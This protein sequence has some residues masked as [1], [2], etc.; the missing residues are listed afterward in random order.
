MPKYINIL[1]PEVYNKIAAGEVVERPASA[2]KEI[3]ENSID[4]GATKIDIEIEQGGLGLIAVTDNGCGIYEEDL[5]AVFMKH[6]T[7]KLASVTD[8][9]SVQ[10]L[11]FRGEALSSIAAVSSVTL[12]TRTSKAEYGTKISVEDGKIISKEYVSCNVGTRI[13]VRDLFYNVPAR[14]KFLKPPAKETAELTRCAQRLILTNFS[15]A[16]SYTLDG[17]TVYE[18]KGQSAEESVYAV[19]GSVCL[20]N[21]LPINFDNGAFFRLNGYIS[22]PEFIKSNTTYQTISVNGRCIEDKT[23]QNSVMQAYK[24]YY[25]GNGRHFPLYVLNIDI[26]S[27]QVDVN[28]HP[29]KTEIRF[30]NIS[31]VAGTCY[32]VVKDALKEFVTFRSMSIMG[33]PDI[34]G[35]YDKVQPLTD[36][37]SESF[38]TS[39]SLF[40]NVSNDMQYAQMQDIWAIDEKTKKQA[41]P[42][43]EEFAEEMEKTLTVQ[44]ARK[45]LGFENEHRVQQPMPS[46]TSAEKVY[47]EPDATDRLIAKIRILGVAFSTY[48]I[49]ELDD[50]I[51]FVDQHAAHERILFDKFMSNPPKTMQPMLFPYV[52]NVNDTEAEFIES[53]IANILK[54]GIEIEPFGK[55]TFR[56][57]AVSTLLNGADMRKF[58]EYM[59]SGINDFRLDDQALIVEALAKKACKAA[60]KAGEAM[61]E[62]EIRYI[63]KMMYENK[64]VRCPHGRPVTYV[65]TKAELEKK[66]MR[67]L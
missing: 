61:S 32:H 37:V 56:I 67:T 52:F 46:L 17:Q 44:N 2:L 4:A 58:V 55:N 3:V 31:A 5:D 21:C 53:N 62:Q 36:D 15:L 20:R 1:P 45:E 43:F 34:N 14:K 16:I 40:G 57:C 6:A 19:Y 27:D 63:L 33:D 35:T 23:I 66:F 7:S 49:L 11:G 12:T 50:K 41:K 24:P 59:L 51:I 30:Q 38:E 42:T 39:G 64:V 54:A 26:V 8:L 22:V 13:E 9:E 25:V 18:T 48:L 28:V 60:V 29:R 65:I 47:P 10:T